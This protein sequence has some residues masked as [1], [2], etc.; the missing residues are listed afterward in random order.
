MVNVE[1]LKKVKVNV[2]VDAVDNK[3]VEVEVEKL[4]KTLP[5]LKA[6]ARVD[7]LRK[8]VAVAEVGSLGDTVA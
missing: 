5:D 6:R 8:K 2:L 3:V 7:T 4:A 1:T